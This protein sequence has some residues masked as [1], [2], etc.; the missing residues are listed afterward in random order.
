MT[1]RKTNDSPQIEQYDGWKKIVEKLEKPQQEQLKDETQQVWKLQDMLGETELGLGEHLTKINE[2]LA[3]F[4]IFVSYIDEFFHM[5]RA[6]A[7]RYM[8]QYK[9]GRKHLPEPVLEAAIARGT[10]IKED[11]LEQFV[12][13]N[14]PPQTQDP[15]VINDYI[16][17]LESV[18]TT[19]VKV[20]TNPEVLEKEIVNF[21]RLRYDRLDLTPQAKAKWGRHVLGLLA[22]VFAVKEQIMVSPIQVPESYVPK[23]G[24]PKD[25]KKAA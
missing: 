25:E 11:V 16:T 5:S 15:K 17:K 7:Y 6:T 20:E 3:P 8:D 23:T 21:S 2:L 22:S 1:A 13:E 18:P 4:R 14:A 10:R 19:P 9:V 12:A 24:R